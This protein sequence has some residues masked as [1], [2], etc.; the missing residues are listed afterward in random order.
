MKTYRSDQSHFVSYKM[1]LK[2][3]PSVGRTALD[4]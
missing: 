2:R 4:N 1:F 3:K